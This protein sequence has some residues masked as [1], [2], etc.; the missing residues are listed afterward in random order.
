[1]FPADGREGLM[2][3]DPET[4][5]HIRQAFADLSGQRSDASLSPPP[6]THETIVRDVRAAFAELD[7]RQLAISRQLTPAQ[8]IQQVCDLNEFLRDLVI[9]AI[10]QQ[11]PDISEAGFEREFLRRMGIQL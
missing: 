6:L 3:V 10:R 9:A 1:V 7:L 4:A 2:V 11:H 8:R 5:F